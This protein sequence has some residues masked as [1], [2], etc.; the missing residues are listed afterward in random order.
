MH[1]EREGVNYE[2]KLNDIFVC[3][4]E[5]EREREHTLIFVFPPLAGITQHGFIIR[6]R[7]QILACIYQKKI[8]GFH[9][10]TF[11]I[12]IFNLNV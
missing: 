1:L 11:I 3:V 2:K 5:R 9:F 12:L 8:P 6:L 7:Y 4:R 10:L